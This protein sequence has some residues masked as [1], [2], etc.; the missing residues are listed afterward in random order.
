[1][2]LKKIKTKE[3]KEKLLLSRLL[4]PLWLLP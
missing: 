4:L 3:G 2:L 1:V